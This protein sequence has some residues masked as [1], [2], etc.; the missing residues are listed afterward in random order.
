MTGDRKKAGE[1]K[2][3]CAYEFDCVYFSSLMRIKCPHTDILPL[4]INLG[5]GFQ[6]SVKIK[7]S[8]GSGLME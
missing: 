8:F 7:I 3:E 4:L 1:R 2:N 5:L 6:L